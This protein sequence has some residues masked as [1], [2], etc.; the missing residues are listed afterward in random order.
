MAVPTT[1]PFVDLIS[2]LLV[3]KMKKS[4]NLKMLAAR[5]M[6]VLVLDVLRIV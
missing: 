5:V 2:G 3:G 1:K 4:W 6:Y